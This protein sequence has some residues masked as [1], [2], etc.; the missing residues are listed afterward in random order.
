MNRLDMVRSRAGFMI[1]RLG[2]SPGIA[3]KEQ[4]ES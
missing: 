1:H 4:D 2:Q 3:V